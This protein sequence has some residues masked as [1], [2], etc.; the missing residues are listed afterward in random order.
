MA[1]RALPA[2]WRR[3]S[4]RDGLLGVWRALSR[5]NNDIHA[6]DHDSRVGY[7]DTDEWRPSGKRLPDTRR[8]VALL[9]A[10]HGGGDA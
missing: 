4:R 10:S 2:R 9:R 3:P 1:V 6:G 5:V 7:L 8:I